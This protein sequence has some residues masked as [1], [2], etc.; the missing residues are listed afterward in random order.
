VR[1]LFKEK[2]AGLAEEIDAGFGFDM[3]RLSIL[4]TAPAEPSQIDLAGVSLGEADLDQLIDRI[5]ARLGP[6]RVSR[7]AAIASHV[8]ERAMQMSDAREQRTENPPPSDLCHPT[9][10]ICPLNRP[11]RLF[12]KP[13]P[14]EAIAEVP[15]GPPVRFRWRRAVYHVARSEGPERIAAEWW[16][17]GSDEPTRDYFRVEDPSGHRFWLFREGLFGRETTAPRW[18]LHGVFG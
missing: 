7:I 10:D 18:Y 12:E 14:V 1:E 15:D 4:A 5:G 11:L 6:E 3:V 16:R 13:E 2:F 8:P 17:D 9:S